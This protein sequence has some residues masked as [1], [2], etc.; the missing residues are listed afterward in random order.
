MRDFLT[1]TISKILVYFLLFFIMPTYYYICN[2]NI[3]NAKISFFVII[4]LLYNPN[5][6]TLTF[7]GLLVLIVLSYLTSCYLLSAINSIL[8]SYEKNKAIK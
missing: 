4:G 8:D 1:P 3:C 2:D 6:G 5:L 7:P